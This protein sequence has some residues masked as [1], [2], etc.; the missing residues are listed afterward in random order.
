MPS[1][2]ARSRRTA[3][4]TSQVMK[5]LQAL[6]GRKGGQRHR[7]LFSFTKT[8]EIAARSRRSPD[9]CTGIL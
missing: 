9:E 4:L 7:A 6:K 8:S 5:C 3:Y 2:S 1:I